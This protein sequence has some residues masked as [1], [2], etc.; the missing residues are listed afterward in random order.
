MT[1]PFF[2]IRLLANCLARPGLSAAATPLL[3]GALVDRRLG[4]ESAHDH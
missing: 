3:S 2:L 1:P 4:G